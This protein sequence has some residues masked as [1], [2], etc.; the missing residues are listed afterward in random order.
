MAPSGDYWVERNRPAPVQPMVALA[1]EQ[2]PDDDGTGRFSFE[3]KMDGFL[4]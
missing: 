2:L 4:N 3:P 1:V